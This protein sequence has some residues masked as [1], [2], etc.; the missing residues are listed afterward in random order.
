[1]FKRTFHCKS[2]PFVVFIL[3]NL[4]S[5][6]KLSWIFDVMESDENELSNDCIGFGFKSLSSQREATFLAN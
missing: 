6:F 5:E 3:L 1:M 4:P 2:V